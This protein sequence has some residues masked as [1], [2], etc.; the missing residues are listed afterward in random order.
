MCRERD[1][2]NGRLVN[3]RSKAT[4]LA[5]RLAEEKATAL[6]AARLDAKRADSLQDRTAALEA[7]LRVR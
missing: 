4:Q 7:R 5:A 6:G 1:E 2:Q 3:E